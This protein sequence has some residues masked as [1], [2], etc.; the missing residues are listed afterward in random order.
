MEHSEGP[1]TLH[2]GDFP[3][4]S[5]VSPSGD[6]CEVMYQGHEIADGNGHILAAALGMLETCKL[7][8]EELERAAHGGYSMEAAA[9]C[10]LALQTI[11]AKAEGT[12][13]EM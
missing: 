12:A 11:I 1:W 9:M 5:V 4:L 6:I 10:R 8:S 13:E 2:Y 7:V 3:L